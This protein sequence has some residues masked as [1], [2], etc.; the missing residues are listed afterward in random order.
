MEKEIRTTHK[1][2]LTQK[3]IAATALQEAALPY[4]T[5]PADTTINELR[6]NL[7]RV[8]VP[9]LA[10][11]LSVEEL[12]RLKSNIQEGALMVAAEVLPHEE[13]VRLGIRADIV[14][15]TSFMQPPT[16][17]SACLIAEAYDV[18]TQDARLVAP[19]RAVINHL[20][21]APDKALLRQAL[22]NSIAQKTSFAEALHA[23]QVRLDD[24]FEES[25]PKPIP[26]MFAKNAHGEVVP[27]ENTSQLPPKDAVV[28]PVEKPKDDDW[29]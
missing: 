15:N 4:E 28:F 24:E 14:D 8:S 5:I 1:N 29:Y 6:N 22:D 2:P 27:V 17:E 21:S 13:A 19:L 25:L 26:E 3:E 23:L 7:Q 11:N 10:E 9:E 20:N 12:S 16:L 18:G